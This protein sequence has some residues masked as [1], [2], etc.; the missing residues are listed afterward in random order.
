[1]SRPADTEQYTANNCPIWVTGPW[2]KFSPTYVYIPDKSMESPF[3]H[4]TVPQTHVMSS[5]TR[6][7]WEWLPVPQGECTDTTQYCSV[8]KRLQLCYLDMYKQMLWLMFTGR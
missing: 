6:G 4:V 5:G 3:Q 8:V 1:M 7:L 2:R